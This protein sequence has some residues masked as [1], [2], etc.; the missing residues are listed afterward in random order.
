MPWEQLHPMASGEGWGGSF[1]TAFIAGESR[2]SFGCAPSARQ[3]A[4]RGLARVDET[5]VSGLLVGCGRGGALP[6]LP[7]GLS[8]RIERPPPRPSRSMESCT[9]S[10]S[11]GA[12]SSKEMPACF[13]ANDIIGLRQSPALWSDSLELPEGLGDMGNVFCWSDN[14]D[15]CISY[16]NKEL[17]SLGLPALYNDNGSG[18]DAKLGFSLL[19]LVNGTCG[20]LNLYQGVSAKLGGLEA[21]EIRRAGELDYLRARQAKLKDQVETCEREIAAVHSKEQQLQSKNKHL[22]DLLRGEKDEITK[23]LNA[24]AS[25]AAQHLHETKRKEQEVTRLKEKMSQLVTEKRD[26]RGT[27]EI[28]NALTR[29]D[30]KRSTWK[31]GKSLVKKEEELYRVQL[32]RQEQREQHLALENAKL[33]KLLTQ[34]GLDVQ[35]Q[36]GTDGGIT[37]GAEQN[38]PYEAFQEQWCQFRDAVRV[39][40]SRLPQ[41]D[42][43]DPVIS[44]TDHDKEIMKLKEEIEQSKALISLQQRCFQE[45]LAASVHAELPAHLQ[46]SYFL[47]E[48]QRLEEERAI[49]EEQR[50]AF[51]VERKNF[52]EAAIRLGW[53]RKQFEEEKALLLKQEFLRSLPRL[54]IRDPKRRL[55][56]PVAAREH[57]H[58]HR[59]SR[60]SRPIS[61]PYPKVVITPSCTPMALFRSQPLS[62]ACSPSP[63]AKAEL[64]RQTVRLPASGPVSSPRL[65]RRKENHQDAACQTE[66]AM[67]DDFPGDFFDCSVE[68][69]FLGHHIIGIHEYL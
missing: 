45:Q 10:S 55:S 40:G 21:E 66:L 35:Q 17:G 61:T 65:S 19:A 23:L 43:Q 12:K 58:L 7:E 28:L 9:V 49:F 54:D 36:M 1:K 51:E 32:A 30:G 2:C 62:P 11:P 57:D 13:L 59:L 8:G 3:K 6:G 27:I 48:Q 41:G 26:K 15:H 64:Y 47:E 14:L 18:A 34:V 38:F 16:L 33:K 39:S 20:L 63:S 31:T 4:G 69:S 68:S 60:G 46:G 53:E 44:I 25:R 37:H 50:Q 29:P 56:A 42:E 5:C 52:T 22:N 24:L 67:E